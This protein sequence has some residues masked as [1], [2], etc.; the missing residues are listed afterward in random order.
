MRAL[1]TGSRGFV[2]GHLVRELACAGRE[3]IETDILEA[4]GRGAGRAAAA[5]W[6]ARGA[7]A[8]GD[9]GPARDS[10]AYEACDLRDAAAVRDLIA[11]RRPQFVFH[12]AAQSS[13]ARSLEDPRG[14]LETNV[15]GALNLFEAARGAASIRILSVGSSEEYGVRSERE[16]PLTEES[17]VEPA[18]PYAVS[19]A[20]QSMLARQ[21]VAAFGLDVVVTRSFSHT[22]PGQTDRFVLPAFAR[23]CA[24]IKAGLREPVVRVGNLDVTRDFTDIRDVVRA[25]RMLAEKGASGE[26]YN[27]C[28]GRALKLSDALDYFLGRSGE[29]VSVERD[30][31][32][33]RPADIPVLVGDST[34]LRRRCGWEPAVATERMLG[35]LF[36]YWEQRIA[37]RGSD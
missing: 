15:F 34:K 16:M 3:V 37:A 17:P 8:S 24:E 9:S 13:A 28:S 5:G 27:V 31:R 25:Y 32:L 19:K 4:P 26:V 30:P 2:G 36:D 23:Q 33:M 14:T 1:V 35:D 10:V 11:R 21:Y 20:A 7:E 22:G 6:T 12:L 29:R 18:S